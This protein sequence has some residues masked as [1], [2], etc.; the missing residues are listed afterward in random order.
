MTGAEW[1]IFDRQALWCSQ[2]DLDKECCIQHCQE[3]DHA[4][5]SLVQYI[6][7]YEKPSA[8]N[9]DMVLSKEIRWKGTIEY[10]NSKDIE[11]WNYTN[12]KDIECTRTERGNNRGRYMSRKRAKEDSTQ[13]ARILNVGTAKKRVT[14]IL[15]A[16]YHQLR[17]KRNK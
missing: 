10:A 8:S 13:I 11:C 17:K 1:E 6:Q 3:N 5:R 15:N 4:E 16:L 7:L 14:L 9:K 2:V 12:R